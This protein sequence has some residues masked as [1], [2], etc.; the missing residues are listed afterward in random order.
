MSPVGEL[1]FPADAQRDR[2]SGAQA[3]MAFLLRLRARGVADVDVL[4]ALEK[5]PRLSFVP[6]RYADL[7]LREMAL[8]IPCGQT[9]GEPFVTAR[10]LEALDLGAGRRVL[11]IGSGSGYS[12]ALLARLADEV[13]SYERFQALAL[14]AKIR[15]RSHGGEK[16]EL[17]W[18]DGLAPSGEK[19]LFDRILVDAIMS[20]EEAALV[21]ERL[22]QGGVM[23]C[24]MSEP[25]EGARLVRF[26]QD[27]TGAFSTSP[28]C[29]CRSSALARGVAKAL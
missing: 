2:Q 25:G 7:A 11:E 5:V 18:G 6:H 10:M 17:I 21:L 27:E 15:L 26:T 23:V 14:E 29:P 13:V 12:T 8:P 16:V 9:I 19:G 20:H 24:A 22:A 3:T 1:N 4:R 28:I